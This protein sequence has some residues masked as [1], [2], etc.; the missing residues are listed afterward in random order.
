MIDLHTLLEDYAPSAHAVTLVQTVP[1]V[2][3][4]GISGA[5]KDSIKRK[6]LE[7]GTYKDFVSFTTRSPRK[8][9]GILEQDG[10]DYHFVTKEKMATLLENGE[11]IE[12]K[13][14]S[15]N[16][17][18]TGILDLEQAARQ[19]KIAI[20]DIE[21]QG[22]REYKKM[23]SSVKAVFIL[24]PSYDVW[25]ER[26]T[27]RYEDGHI[28]PD[29]LHK[30]VVTAELELHAALDSSDYVF[31]V[32]DNLDEAVQRVDAIAHGDDHGDQAEHGRSV[33]RALLGDL[34]AV[35]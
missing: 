2:L 34:Q 25:R 15:G 7:R 21:V 13:E 29:E 8:N 20:N 19:D 24:P 11:M 16:V 31:V 3:M 32:N 1:I 6:L 18:G 5:G 9:Q 33:A 26:L 4:V 28:E 17:Y 27:N 10:V 30:R 12:A 22:V 14:Y 23:A 35:Q